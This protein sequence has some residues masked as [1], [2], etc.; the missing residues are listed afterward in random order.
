[1]RWAEN[2]WRPGAGPGFSGR[3]NIERF[4]PRTE[5]AKVQA[6]YGMYRAA[7]PVDD[8]HG[9]AMSF[10]RFADALIEGWEGTPQEC[11][12]IP[13][14]A[15]GVWPGYYVLEL[16]QHENT[17][18]APVNLIVPLARRRAGIGTAMLRH[19]ADRAVANGR[20]LLR[21]STRADSAGA[22]FA[23]AVGA[24]L[25]GTEVKR[26]LDV[27][28]IPDGLLAGLR[29]EAEPKAAGYS[30][31]TWRDE[32][33]EEYIEPSVAAINALGDSPLDLGEEPE[34]YDAARIRESDEQCIRQGLRMYSVAAWHDATGTMAGITQVAVDEGVEDW[35]LQFITAVVREHRGHRLG[36]LIKVAMLDWLAAAEPQLRWIS[37]GNAQS[38]Q[39]M[40]G[41][42]ARLGFQVLGSYPSWQLDAAQFLTPAAASHATALA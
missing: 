39:Y 31:L 24:Q 36:M 42:N 1:M 33:P 11:W 40:I 27:R 6:C 26:G 35:G 8:P 5:P 37:T 29:A 13:R 9:P 25:A 4:D 17:H 34:V 15:D 20:T 32:T 2:Q 14:D 38:N 12:L 23:L 18:M 30:V 7:R 21:D 28:A 3:V 41:I 22:A 10:R 16:P 19:A